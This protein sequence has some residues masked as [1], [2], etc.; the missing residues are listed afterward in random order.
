MTDKCPL[1]G[2]SGVIARENEAAKA[3]DEDKIREIGELLGNLHPNWYGY[4]LYYLLGRAEGDAKARLVD[5]LYDALKSAARAAEYA[6]E[7]EE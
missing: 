6:K 4:A 1:Y 5:A 2:V 7:C 3:T